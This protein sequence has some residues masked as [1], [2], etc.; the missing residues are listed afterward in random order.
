MTLF[1]LSEPLVETWCRPA[2]YCQNKIAT[3]Q[4]IKKYA[5]HEHV[6]VH[7]HLALTTYLAMPYSWYY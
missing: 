3:P 2:V 5:L 1:N 6:Y 7:I 4:P